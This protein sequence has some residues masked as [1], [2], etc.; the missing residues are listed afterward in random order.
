MGRETVG[1]MVCQ[2][3]EAT[4]RGGAGAW[5][6]VVTLMTVAIDL[7]SFGNGIVVCGT[8]DAWP[9]AGGEVIWL[10]IKY[11]QNMWAKTQ[12]G[13]GESGILTLDYEGL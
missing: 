13:M 6:C 11:G 9:D 4:G 12:Y 5:L 10:L 1:A 2:A 7:M 8:A 3:D